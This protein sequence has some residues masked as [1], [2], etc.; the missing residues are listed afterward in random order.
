M[1]LS[2]IFFKRTLMLFWVLWWL[3][4]FLTDLGGAMLQLGW[5]SENWLPHSIYPYLVK[6]IALYD[7][8][9]FLARLLFAGII[10]WLFLSTAFFVRAVFTSTLRRD[11][12]IAR[13]NSAFI[14][15]LA[16]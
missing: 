15:S 12:W 4:A 5:F 2:L 3:V 6:T 16:L 14:N 1:V 11:V 13:V 10:C 7:P 9:Q 8:R